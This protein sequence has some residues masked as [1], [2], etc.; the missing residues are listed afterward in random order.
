[1]GILELLLTTIGGVT[2]SGLLLYSGSR[3]TAKK[4]AEVSR[5]LATIEERKVGL[6]EFRAFTERYNADMG[7]M[8][9]DLERSKEQ[10]SE[11]RNILR[12]A[13]THI[14]SLRN[15]MRRNAIYPEPLPMELRHMP[16]LWD[17]TED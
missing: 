5:T 17:I 11:S 8:R 14:G 13:I 7:Q 2:I 3:Y 9:L 1:M 12:I 6:E 15:T 10:L 16:T 4:S